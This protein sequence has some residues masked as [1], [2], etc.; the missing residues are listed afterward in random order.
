MFSKLI[1]KVLRFL[2]WF[3]IIL[4]VISNVNFFLWSRA[5]RGLEVNTIYGMGG[6]I[7]MVTGF[8]GENCHR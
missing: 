7:F 5:R 6:K 4:S 3:G 1:G 8:Y 2:F